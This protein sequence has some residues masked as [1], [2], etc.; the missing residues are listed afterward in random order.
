MK[1]STAT[2]YM[3]WGL[4]FV[5]FYEWLF[6]FRDSV[7]EVTDAEDTERVWS[8]TFQSFERGGR[9]VGVGGGV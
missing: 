8:R 9:G 3:Q 2:K 5:L 4:G 6:C 1:T 7:S